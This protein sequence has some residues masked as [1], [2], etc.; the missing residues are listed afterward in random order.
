[1]NSKT[2]DRVLLRAMKH[3]NE[4]MG[5]RYSTANVKHECYDMDNA[6]EMFERFCGRYFPNRLGDDYRSPG[7]FRDSIAM[8]F[9]GTECDGIPQNGR[10]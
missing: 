9:T 8:A 6:A 1:M 5:T 2:T 10:R 3:F 4:K 7:Y